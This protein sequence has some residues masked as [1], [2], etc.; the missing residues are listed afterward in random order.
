MLTENLRILIF[1]AGGDQLLE[2]EEVKILIKVVEEIADSRIIAV[3]IDN[4]AAEVLAV[5]L[6]FVLDID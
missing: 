6:E 3:A 1:V 2:T 4:L 5:M